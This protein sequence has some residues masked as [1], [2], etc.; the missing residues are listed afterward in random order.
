MTPSLPMTGPKKKKEDRDDVVLGICDYNTVLQK[1]KDSSSVA[2]K[3]YIEI[4]NFA[5]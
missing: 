4:N 2:S 1:E 3:G 5:I